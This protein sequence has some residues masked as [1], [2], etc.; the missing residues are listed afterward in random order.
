MARVRNYAAEQA[1]R[2]Q[3]A[4]ELGFASYGQQ[5]RVLSQSKALA[6]H[7]GSAIRRFLNQ[8]PENED[9]PRASAEEQRTAGIQGPTS[10]SPAPED[11]DYYWPTRTSNAMRPRTRQ[12]RYSRNLQRLEVIFDRPSPASP[13]GTWHYDA[14]PPQVW[15]NFKRHRSPGIYINSVLN[16]FPYGSGG[17]GDIVGE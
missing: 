9:F 7:P 4:R 16:D 8:S 15:N 5:R 6:S 3:K 12:A 14:V 17:W 1:A 10:T 13:D 2:E 11:W